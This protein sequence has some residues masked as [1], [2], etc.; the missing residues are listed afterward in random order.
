MTVALVIVVSLPSAIF[1]HDAARRLFRGALRGVHGVS[2]RGGTDAPESGIADGILFLH[3]DGWRAGG[4]RRELAGAVDIPKLLGVSAGRPWVHCGAVVC[5]DAGTFLLVAQG[6]SFAGAADS[7]R[8]RVA[9]AGR[10]CSRM[11]G[12][13]AVAAIGRRLRGRGPVPAPRFRGMRWSVARPARAPSPLLVRNASRIV[14]ALLTVGLLIP[15]KAALY[16]VIASS[17]DFYGVLSVVSVSDENYLALRYGSTVHGF[18]YQDAQRARLA[19]G[20]YGP[21]SG[22]NI[23]IRNWPQHPM[24]VGLVGMGVGTLAALAPIRRR[25]PLLRNQSGR[26]QIV[27]WRPSLLHLLAGFARPNRGG[28]GRCAT[29][30]R[31]GSQPRRLREVRRSGAGRVFERRDPHASPHARSIFR[32]PKH[33]RGPASVIAVH[34]SNQTLDLRPVLAG[35]GRDF[36]FHA[37][38]VDSL[39]RR[40]FLAVRLDFAFARS[41]LRCPARSWRNTR[42][43]FRRGRSPS[44]GPTIIAI[45]ST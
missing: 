23:V 13:G 4:H 21:T 26:L 29:L 2:R 1:V 27:E 34:I 12:G 6:A 35:I 32:L 37:V 10:A 7:R 25:L 3:R 30:A 16:H 8:R 38:R 45:C 19:T 14:L 17:R 40:P 28:P 15:Q 41:A 20:Y 31:R 44:P 24:R 42:N 11:E 22:A 33:L 36:G 5:L 39:C 18:Q 9:C 43:R